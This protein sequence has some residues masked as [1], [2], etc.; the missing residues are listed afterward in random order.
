MKSSTYNKLR[1]R[2]LEPNMSDAVVG[3]W[4]FANES[5][6]DSFIDKL[7]MSNKELVNIIVLFIDA[8]NSYNLKIEIKDDEN[9]HNYIDCILFK[10]MLI[11]NYNSI[12]EYTERVLKRKSNRTHH[13]VENIKI[14]FSIDG[15]VYIESTE[16]WFPK[17]LEFELSQD[18]LKINACNFAYLPLN[19]ILEE[20]HYNIWALN[21]P[22]L[23]SIL[24]SVFNTSIFKWI[25]HSDPDH[26]STCDQRNPLFLINS[27]KVDYDY[28]DYEYMPYEKISNIP[29][30]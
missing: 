20:E 13:E 9:N 1:I 26:Y 22:L 15:S 5:K 29:T 27:P 12:Y 23:A 4:L 21:A 30:V 8:L 7:I 11:K 25:Y 18:L 14:V 17:L 28:W 19:P 2:T 3:Q 16:I 24:K 6:S 10:T